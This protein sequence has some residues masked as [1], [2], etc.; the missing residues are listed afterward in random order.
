MEKREKIRFTLEEETRFVLDLPS[1]SEN[2][3]LDDL[4]DEED[5]GPRNTSTGP[6]IHVDDYITV[7]EN[8]DESLPVVTNER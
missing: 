4:S 5:L 2:W 7:T 8:N 1:D 6:D 3:D